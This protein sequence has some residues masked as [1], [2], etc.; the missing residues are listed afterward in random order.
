MALDL[1][2][3]AGPEREN[4][5]LSLVK[6]GLFEAS[7]AS[8]TS[9]VG[10]NTAEFQVFSDAMKIEGVRV[11]V[12]AE[13]AQMVADMLGCSLLTPKLAD[14]MWVQRQVTLTPFPRP[15]TAT[16]AAMF[17]HSAQIDAALIA[18]GNPKG[19]IQTVGKHWVID[20]ALATSP[21]R[22]MN[23]GWHFSGSNYQG[24]AGEAT[25]SLLKAANG[26]Y[27][28]MIQ[29]RGTAH[30]MH[31]VDYSQICVLVSR[32][33]K[34]NGVDMDLH[35]VLKDPHLASLASHQGVLSVLRQPGVPAPT[36][37]TIVL[38]EITIEAPSTGSENIA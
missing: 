11:N 34:V 15:I 27:V 16:T 8:I 2:P 10:V 22:A 30:D 25:A 29:G 19:L 26:S 23:Y 24:I 35:D 32:S 12:S 33:C 18:Q 9:Q 28:R 6:Q 13:T 3:N 7:W 20:Q 4:A 21:G 14:L 36:S 17:A 1:P 38:P 31:H 37:T 5:I